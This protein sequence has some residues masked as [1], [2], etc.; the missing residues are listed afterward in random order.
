[1]GSYSAAAMKINPILH[2]PSTEHWVTAVLFICL[3]LL[4]WVKTVYPKKLFLVF[5][6]AFVAS[7]PEE[8][9]GISP[10]SIALFFIFI[11]SS[12]LLIMQLFHGSLARL[13]SNMGEEFAMLT[14]FI[15]GF[16]IA[17]T[18]LILLCGFIFEEQQS[19]AEYLSEVYVF[20]HVLG[21][22]LLPLVML[23]TYSHLIDTVLFERIILIAIALLFIYRTIKM[24][25]IMTNKGLNM[26]Y[27][28]L[29]ICTLEILPL[30]LFY[31]YGIMN[32]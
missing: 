22:I 19:A 24:F 12:V 17:K 14:L 9:S 29:Y 32:L 13:Y 7:L 30:A 23:E 27:L 1:V 18:L 5:K 8:D 4:A 11:C 21:V 10:A 16:Y 3:L 31:R 20:T 15:G 26:M 6:D 28:F 2:F 25:I